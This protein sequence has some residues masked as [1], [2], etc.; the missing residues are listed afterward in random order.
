MR[1]KRNGVRLLAV[2]LL[3]SVLAAGM[4]TAPT[5]EAKTKRWTREQVQQEYEKTKKAV[6]VLENKYQTEQNQRSR[7]TAN[8]T[9]IYG[10][11]ICANP[12]IIQDS[13][14]IW[15]SN[16]LYWVA[17]GTENVTNMLIYASAY[18]V[19]TGEY[20]YYNYTPC[21]VCYA[22]EKKSDAS[23]VKA[24][25]DKKK[26]KLENLKHALNNSV[27]FAKKNPKLKVGDK[28]DLKKFIGLR[29]SEHYN[30]VEVEIRPKKKHATMSKDYVIKGKKPGVVTLYT[31]TTV[32]GKEDKI[33]IRVVK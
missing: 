6:G 27:V 15:N 32:S 31:W 30:T 2:A 19:T 25:L 14:D 18:V 10:K 4:I 11:V 21:A 1:K 7:E 12:L 28:L 20:R 5:A 17:S 13:T 8:A 22:V 16:S 33:K 29:Y 24:R 9:Y 3:L 23:D 26:R